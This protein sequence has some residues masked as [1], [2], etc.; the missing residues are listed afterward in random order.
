ML[1]QMGQ[2]M[3][4]MSPLLNGSQI[5]SQVALLISPD[6]RWAFQ[7]QPVSN[8]I[9]YDVTFIKYHSALRSSGLNVDVI[10]TSQLYQSPNSSSN[11]L[12]KYKVVFA[13]LLFVVDSIISQTLSSYVNQGG[14]LV[15]T[16]RSGWKDE[17]SAVT[18]KVLPG[19]LSQLAGVTIHTWSPIF[20]SQTQIVSAFGKSYSAVTFMDILTAKTAQIIGTYQKPYY[21][22]Q[23]AIT[24]NK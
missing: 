12:N 24:V 5:Q 4:E 16:Y 13:P 2:E 3:A 21:A 18:D 19:L 14:K 7:E 20:N 23:A 8:Q 15:L 9:N 22:N 6:S 1:M 17:F 10:F 11:V